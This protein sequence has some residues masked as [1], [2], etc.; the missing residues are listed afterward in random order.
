MDYNAVLAQVLALLQQEQR[1]SYRVLKLRLQ[2]D[3]D[4]LEALKEDLIYAKKLA[5]D[6]DGRVLVWTGGTAS[7]PPPASSVPLPATPDISPAQGEAAP[8]VPS[9]PDAERRQLTVLFCDLVDSTAL[10]SQLDPEDLR[11]VV[12]AYQASCAEVIQRFEGYIAQYLGDGL[13]VYFGYPFAHEDDAQRAVRAGLGMV[14]A[15][16]QLNTRLEQERGVRLAVRL[17]IHTGLVVVGEMGAGGRQ[18]QLALGDTPNIAARLQGLAAPD[19]VVISAATQRLIQGYFTCQALGAQALK[20]V[21][22]PLEIHQVVRATDVQ[23]RLDVA[24]PH[25]LTPLVGREHEVMILRERWAQAQ[26]GQGHVV[27]LSGEAGIGKS[28]LVQ[29]VKDAIIGAATVRIEYRCSPYHQYSAL[30]PVITHLERALAWRPDETPEARLRKLE[31]ALRPAPLPLGAMV[32]LVAALLSL[33]L[34]ASYPPLTLTPQRQKQKTLEALL[35]W[36]LALT[37][38]QP[39]LFVVE[40]LHWIDPSTLEFLTLLVDQGPTARLLTLLTC[41]PEFQPP[42]GLRTH[43]TPMVLQRLPQPQVEAMIVRV[44][45]GKALPPEV[46]QHIVTKTDGV[47]LFVEELTQTV[48]ESGLLR[49]TQEHYELTG[50]LPPLAIPAT[51]HDSLMARL[52]RLATVKAVAQLGAVLGR[53]FSYALLQ[54]MTRLDEAS[55]QHALALLVEAELLYQR[56]VPPQATYLF[57][58][59]LIQDAAYQSLLKSTRQ[60]YHQRIA[61]VLE[62]QFSE[63]AATQPELLAHHYTEAGLNAQAVGYWH[64]AGQRASA[65]SAHLEAIN[66]LRHGL[67]VLQMLPET[68]ERTQREV[69]MLITLGASLLAVKGYAA[70]EVGETYTYAQQRCHHLDDPQRL[71]PVVRGLWQYANVR[72]EYQTAYALGEQLWTLAQGMRQDSAMRVAAHRALGATLFWMGAVAAAQTHFAQGIALYDPEQHRALAFLYGE[73]TGAIC[74]SFSAFALWYLGYPDQALARSQEAVTLAQ[75]SVHPF[76]LSHVLSWRAQFHQYRREARCTQEYAEPAISLATDQGFPQWMTV[77][78]MLRG[79][80]LVHQGQAQEGMAQIT[81]G[82]LTYWTTASVQA[83]PYFLAL[84]AEAHHIQGE[85]AAGLTVLAEALAL[86]DTIGERCFEPELY[87][88]KGE[89]LLQQHVDNQADAETCFQQALVVAQHQQAKSF[90]LRAT[91]SLARLWQQQG[92]RQEAHDLLVPVYDWFTEGFDTPDLQDAQALL[93]AL[94]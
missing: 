12:R 75:Q 85:A 89:L 77:S 76:S 66:H 28:R 24:T 18:E 34:P 70:C 61:D 36:L 41:R 54:A 50:P 92:K 68:P 7:A 31:E 16:G 55:L 8:V 91:S 60:Q 81:Q 93:D 13:L 44:T 3:D 14:E 52:D 43:L 48:L 79:W 82:V 2:L 35:T 84:L 83:R 23:H 58:H 45:G 65:R 37:E 1:L 42:W 59:A 51:L 56:G 21:A 63:T 6:E 47:P 17:G 86:V 27:L 29:V 53:T 64:H 40:D 94:A 4:T 46:L 62:A 87:R 11:E 26:A 5:V 57:K 67:S 80:A 30:Y 15:V 69:D 32:P 49:E 20:G 72:A 74:H 10:S 78:A 19:T 25:G 88:L 22:T 9:T 73:D 39:I 38:Q 90:E 33:P 71:F